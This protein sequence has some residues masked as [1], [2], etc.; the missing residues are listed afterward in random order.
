MKLK[1]I[2]DLV[3]GWTMRSKVYFTAS[4]FKEVPSWKSDIIAQFEDVFGRIVIDGPAGGKS[5]MESAERLLLDQ[6]VKDMP[7]NHLD[8]GERGRGIVKRVDTAADAEGSALLRPV[9]TAVRRA[10]SAA[11]SRQGT[12]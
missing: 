7:H 1:P 2:C 4:A 5:G 9:P 6:G 12:D 8:A 10:A 11:R 3:S